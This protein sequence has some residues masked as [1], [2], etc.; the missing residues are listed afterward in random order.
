MDPLLETPGEKRA[1]N[2]FLRSIGTDF[3]QSHYMMNLRGATHID[4]VQSFP[5]LI[6]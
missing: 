4:I 2:Q 1:R 5:S 6:F 3:I